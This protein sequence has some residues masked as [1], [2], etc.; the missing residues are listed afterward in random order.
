VPNSSIAQQA[1]VQE[2]EYLTSLAGLDRATIA[3]IGAMTRS[4]DAF[5]VRAVRSAI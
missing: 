4:G 5:A 3:T 1:D 2:K